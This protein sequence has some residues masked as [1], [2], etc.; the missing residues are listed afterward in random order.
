MRLAKPAAC[1]SSPPKK[2]RSAFAALIL[3]ICVL[4][5]TAWLSVCLDG[6]LELV[7]FPLAECGA[8]VDDRNAFRLRH[9][10][11]VDACVAGI[12]RVRGNHHEGVR[13]AAAGNDRVRRGGVDD[14]N[15]CLLINLRGGNRRARVEVAD[16]HR[17]A[18]I[19]QLLR[20]LH[21]DARVRLVVL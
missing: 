15:A 6:F 8:V 10:D 1:V 14:R 21:A 7:G 16:H 19:H 18:R 17:N 11:C 2:I 5:S 4:K 3:V 9:L 13:K 20:D 12:L